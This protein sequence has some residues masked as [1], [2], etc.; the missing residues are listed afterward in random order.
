[1]TAGGAL[2]NAAMPSPAIIKPVK[3]V[4]PK[5]IH[6]PSTRVRRIDGSMQHGEKQRQRVRDAY[7]GE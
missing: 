7:R 5:Y 3:F 4:A 1:M 2:L 6:P